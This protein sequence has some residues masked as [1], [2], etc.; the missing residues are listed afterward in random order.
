MVLDGNLTGKF[1][2]ILFN[3]YLPIQFYFSS[4]N[5]VSCSASSTLKKSTSALIISAQPHN[6][7]SEQRQALDHIFTVTDSDINYKMEESPRKKPRKS[8]TRGIPHNNGPEKSIINGNTSNDSDDQSDKV[9]SVCARKTRRS[10]FKS[11][12]EADVD[13]NT[14]NT[15]SAKKERSL[16]SDVVSQ[17]SHT[18]S[19]PNGKS[20]QCTALYLEINTNSPKTGTPDKRLRSKVLS[21]TASS[22][23]EQTES[24]AEPPRKESLVTKDSGQH[25]KAKEYM[26]STS[27]D[28]PAVLDDQGTAISVRKSRRSKVNNCSRTPKHPVA[29]SIFAGISSEEEQDIGVL[30]VK[31]TPSKRTRRSVLKI[32]TYQEDQIQE[33]ENILPQKPAD[34]SVIK[35]EVSGEEE[36][37][38]LA[39]ICTPGKSPRRTVLKLPLKEDDQSDS[40]DSSIQARIT[41]RR[42]SLARL[43]TTSDDGAVSNPSSCQKKYTP[44][45]KPR[46]SVVSVMSECSLKEKNC[47]TVLTDENSKLDSNNIEKEIRVTPLR[48]SRRL[49]AAPAVGEKLDLSNTNSDSDHCNLNSMKTTRSTRS[50]C[51]VSIP[52][53]RDTVFTNVKS[54]QTN[55]HLISMTAIPMEV[56][57]CIGNADKHVDEN[58][59]YQKQSESEDGHEADTHVSPT[60]DSVFKESKQYNRR[61]S[62]GSKMRRVTCSGIGNSGSKRKSGK[63]TPKSALCQSRMRSRGS[64]T[65]TIFSPL[66]RRR[67]S[68]STVVSVSEEGTSNLRGLSVV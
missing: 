44:R 14:K 15:P 66:T 60:A 4:D 36:I 20:S 54:D 34:Q 17:R 46:R 11:K 1:G 67:K 58:I 35:K 31:S 6:V 39:V 28:E 26:V 19:S 64:T 56:E 37:T 41:P 33:R 45:T 53:E 65:P 24:E 61:K 18:K 43:A 47:A 10:I 29:K 30:E 21:E 2:I 59:D 7:F 8:I 55:A 12:E 49:V 13:A 42:K 52:L 62:V 25:L 27:E 32:S 48:M 5:E 16:T 63:K 22:A 40:S 57:N 50:E 38:N 51:S 3:G 9:D 68:T 23:E